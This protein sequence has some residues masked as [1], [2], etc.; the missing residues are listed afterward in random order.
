MKHVADKWH[1]QRKA[2]ILLVDDRPENLLALEGLLSSPYYNLISVSSGEEALKYVLTETIAVILLD[3]Q[4]PGLD[5]FETAKII[6]SRQKS[7][8][9]PIIFITAISQAIE[10]VMQGFEAGAID[11]ILKPFHPETLKMKVDAFVKIHQYQEQ[12]KLQNKIMK[13]MGETLDDTVITFDVTGTILT[14][15]PA[16]AIMF[17]Y[18][19]DEIIGH[20]INTLVPNLSSQFSKEREAGNIVETSALRK[21]LSYF[22]ADVQLGE[23]RITGKRVFVCSIRDVTKRKEIEE[24]RF[25]KIFEATPCLVSLRS[26]DDWKYINVNKSWLSYSGYDNYTD[27]ID[28][29]SDSLTY[30]IHS[31]DM[32]ELVLELSELN[33]PVHNIRISYLNHSGEMREGLLSSEFLDAHG[34]ACLLTVITDITERALVEKE[35]VRLDRLNSVGEMASGIVHEIRNP[36]TTI[37]GFLQMSKEHPSSEFV[38]I[39]I[40]ELDR[41][42]DIL[43]EFLSI[44][45]T[46]KSKQTPVELNAIIKTLYPLLQ[47]KAMYSNKLVRLELGPCPILQLNEDEIKQLLLNL[48]LNGLESMQSGG[49]LTIKT[50]QQDEEI[51]LAIQDEGYGIKKELLEKIGTPFFS[52]K[53]NGT[54][55]GLSICQKVAERQ[56]ATITIETSGNGTTFFV[57]FP[58]SKTSSTMVTL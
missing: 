54:G 41:A 44:S 57:H 25:R 49:A 39:M 22:P 24:E 32:E 11:Y 10:H 50:Y 35:M 33:H 8:Q 20:H 7:K 17:G 30:I 34:E 14:I 37:R 31:E 16:V 58:L 45:R 18:S 42:H 5:G 23:A 51:I 26:L 21:N 28:Q 46:D 48:S 38:D 40:E 19:E 36:L 53:S 1:I 3:V 6:K 9:V 56:H 4:M 2:N 13:V 29:S 52:T 47:A 15:N 27:I 43:S 12:I 55:L